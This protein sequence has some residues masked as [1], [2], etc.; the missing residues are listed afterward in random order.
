M[1]FHGFSA[2]GVDL[3]QLNRLQNSKELYD[4]H[5]DEI[6]RLSIRPFHELIA[7]MTPEMVKIDPQFVT[8]PSR[9][10][11]RVRRDTR[12]TK[13]KTLYRANMWLFFR[14]ARRERES[15]PAYYFELHPEYWA[16]GCWG[17][18]G[19]GEMEALREM[20]LAEDRLFLDAF[21]AVNSCPQVHLAGEM[22]KRPKFPDA[23]PEYQ[24]WLNRKE[25][26][27]DYTNGEDFTPVLDGTFVPFML[28]TMRQLAPLYRLL[29]AAKE[30]ADAAGR[31]ALQ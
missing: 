29:L 1:A 2:E 24:D 25:I 15:V 9:M 17:A 14:R 4:A 22:Y 20:I 10:V 28:K 8:V 7:E 31:E 27:V 26:G 16:F 23:K 13:D 30:R 12:Y 19:R 18:W 11:S 6:K 3:L 21:R 5:K